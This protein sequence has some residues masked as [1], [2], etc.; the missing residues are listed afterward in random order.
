MPNTLDPNNGDAA[1]EDVLG[2]NGGDFGDKHS[3]MPSDELETSNGS[4]E[5]SVNADTQL[6]RALEE[7]DG[8]FEGGMN[9]SNVD[10]LDPLGANPITSNSSEP[11][12]EELGGN[13]EF[14]EL[15]DSAPVSAA[16]T[17]ETADAEV[18]EA[19]GS[20][21][22]SQPV[23]DDIG[24]GRGDNVIERQIR[25]AALQEKDPVLRKELWDEYRRMKGQKD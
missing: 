3:N 15:A 22:A 21:D 23:P 25:Q 1:T 14:E 24:D 8:L 6:D 11:L 17:I 16:S 18:G 9:D 19:P 13:T 12:F 5:P 4:M 7:F 2:E 10:I 20:V